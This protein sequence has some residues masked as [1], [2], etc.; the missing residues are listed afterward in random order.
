MYKINTILFGQ[1]TTLHLLDTDLKSDIIEDE[2][3]EYFDVA[4]I[5]EMYEIFKHTQLDTV[6]DCGAHIGLYSHFF[7][8]KLDI[9]NI[10]AIEPQQPNCEL[11]NIN[12]PSATVICAAVGDVISKGTLQVMN[13]INSQ[14]T[15]VE[16]VNDNHASLDIITIDSLNIQQLSLMKIDVEG[17][18]LKTLVGSIETINR[19]KPIIYVEIH[20]D[21]IQPSTE[22]FY[23]FIEKIG[24]KIEKTFTGYNELY[25]NPFTPPAHCIHKLIP[26]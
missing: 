15:R 1:P 20:P 24:Y 26:R 13:S 4:I 6:V 8:K 14:A 19:C 9:K 3:V 23:T 25:G 7:E 10:I 18:E 2:Y 5:E 12:A 11:I 22:V 17:Y 21:I 16:P